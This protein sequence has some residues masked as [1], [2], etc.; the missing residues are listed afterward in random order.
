MD[1]NNIFDEVGIIEAFIDKTKGYNDC[2]IEDKVM[3]DA[4]LCGAEDAE[5]INKE[6]G[7]VNVSNIKST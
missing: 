5:I 1:T 7:F 3:E 2:D 4:I 6:T